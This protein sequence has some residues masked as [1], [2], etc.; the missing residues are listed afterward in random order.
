MSYGDTPGQPWR[1]NIDLAGTQTIDLV[2]PEDFMRGPSNIGPQAI[3]SRYGIVVQ[4]LSYHY[5]SAGAAT[6][7]LIAHDNPWIS[8]GSV[9]DDPLWRHDSAGAATVIHT[10]EHCSWAIG[11]SGRRFEAG[12]TP[13]DA[14]GAVLQL[15]STGITDGFLSVWGIQSNTPSGRQAD[16]GS[17]TTF[18]KS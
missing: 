12:G 6:F 13:T 1:I 11:A 17:P 4:G 3:S 15:A 10:I 2:V 5:T 9:V 18:V 14:N 8:I 7:A 16:T